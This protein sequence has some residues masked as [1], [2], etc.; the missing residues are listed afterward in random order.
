VRF[1]RQNLRLLEPP[2]QRFDVLFCRNVVMY[3]EHDFRIELARYYHRALAD[4]GALFL[5][6]SESLHGMPR[7]FVP[8]KHGRSLYYVKAPLDGG[9]V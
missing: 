7:I 6:S 9:G 2:G 8:L 4:D 5:G 1:K 3:F